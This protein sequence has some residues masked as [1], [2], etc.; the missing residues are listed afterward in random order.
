MNKLLIP[1][2]RQ[3]K[4]NDGSGVL[5]GLDLE[6]TE[7]IVEDLQ[8]KLKHAYCGIIGSDSI[9]GLDSCDNYKEWLQSLDE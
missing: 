8:D 6:V 9:V 5:H 7:K 4:H 1:A 2:L 3:Y